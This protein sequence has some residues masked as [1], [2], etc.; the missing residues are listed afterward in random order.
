MKTEIIRDLSFQSIDK[1]KLHGT[2][3]EEYK[4]HEKLAIWK[5]PILKS[6]YIRQIQLNFLNES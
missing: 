5:V 2:I 4:L 3:Y 1:A 6:K